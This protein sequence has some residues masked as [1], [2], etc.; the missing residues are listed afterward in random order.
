MEPEALSRNAPQAD[1]YH[2]NRSRQVHS[3]DGREPVRQQSSNA[4]F[5]FLFDLFPGNHDM[6]SKIICHLAIAGRHLH[7]GQK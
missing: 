7:H 4:Q 6:D 2:D 1:A 3:Q 5:G